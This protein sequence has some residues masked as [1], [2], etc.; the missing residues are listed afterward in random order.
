MGLLGK[1]KELE[2]KAGNMLQQDANSDGSDLSQYV[3][4]VGA[5]TVQQVSDYV[6]SQTESMKRSGMATLERV[7]NRVKERPGQSVGIAFAA[8]ILASYL[9]RRGK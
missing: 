6:N 9:L 8:G 2:H 3:R 4:N 5:E 7:E 1:T